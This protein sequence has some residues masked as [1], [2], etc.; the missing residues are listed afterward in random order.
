L[1][2]CA[3]IQTG[4]GAWF[5]E[6]Q[7]RLQEGDER[8]CFR[9]CHLLY[10]SKLAALVDA[11]LVEIQTNNVCCHPVR[12]IKKLHHLSKLTYKPFDGS[13]MYMFITDSNSYI[14]QG[15]LFSVILQIQ[16]TASTGLFTEFVILKIAQAHFRSRNKFSE[17]S[18]HP[19]LELPVYPTE[20]IKELEPLNL[21]M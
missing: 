10:I 13:W 12:R 7:D 18:Q 21:G 4:T 20:A 3:S 19:R 1:A 2:G 16:P 15:R 6:R 8:Y 14:S 11:G 9:P 17:N 5:I